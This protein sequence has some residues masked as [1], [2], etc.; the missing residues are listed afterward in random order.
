MEIDQNVNDAC[1]EELILAIG[2]I[3]KI[4]Q[5]FIIDNR[6]IVVFENELTT[7]ELDKISTTTNEYNICHYIVDPTVNLAYKGQNKTIFFELKETDTTVGKF[8]DGGIVEN[9]TY[10]LKRTKTT[11]HKY[12]Q[13][14]Y[15]NGERISIYY[16]EETPNINE[17]AKQGAE[18]L[19]L[20]KNQKEI[21]EIEESNSYYITPE[22]AV[23]DLFIALS[24]VDLPIKVIKH[25][26]ANNK[27]SVYLDI[28]TPS[29]IKKVRVSNHKGGTASFMI[30]VNFWYNQKTKQDYQNELNR[31]VEQIIL[32]KKKDNQN[33]DNDVSEMEDGGIVSENIT[34]NDFHLATFANYIKIKSKEVP[35]VEPNFISRSGSKYWYVEDYVVRQSDH[36]GRTIASCNWLL[37]GCAYKGLSQGKCKLSDFERTNFGKLIAGNKYKVRKTSL[38]RNGGGCMDI[39]V[40]EGVFLKETIDFYIFDTFR[41]GQQSLAS[42]KLLETMENGGIVDFNDNIQEIKDKI[43]MRGQFGENNIQ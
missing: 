25:Y 23:L 10:K 8:E 6:L 31:V 41:V 29:G 3:K 38:R 5:W 15:D 28:Q 20:K 19:Q 12:V 37:N 34:F 26:Q 24:K 2:S 40:K 35:Q 11:G 39:E 43:I 22:L 9:F 14:T 21:E 1:V 30:D 13:F 27:M 7:N 16:N 33:L 4:Y 36:W 42:V 17:L 32:N 18:K